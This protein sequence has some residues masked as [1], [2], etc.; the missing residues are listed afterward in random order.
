MQAAEREPATRKIKVVIADDHTMFRQGLKEML[1]TDEG[2]EVIGEAGDGEEALSL[3]ERLRPDIL[4]L[5]IEMPVLDAYGVMDRLEESLSPPKVVMVTMFENAKLVREFFDR[6]ASGYL[7]KSASLKELVSAV[8]TVYETPADQI[9]PTAS[10]GSLEKPSEDESGDLSERE[11]EILLLAARG[12]SNRQAAN[13]LHLADATIKR[14]LANIY[15]KL[16]VG[17]RGEAARKA[18][19]EGWIS[20]HDLMRE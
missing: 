12:L 10:R 11:L 6:G 13:H 3:V 18:L 17:S 16:G 8:H 14:H 15:Q 9:T 2:I 1:T 4:L 19:S 20:T 5:D 7:S